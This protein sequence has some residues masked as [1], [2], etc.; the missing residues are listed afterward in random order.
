MGHLSPWCSE[1]PNPT[2]TVRGRPN[3]G[4]N[5][6]L[7][8]LGLEDLSFGLTQTENPGSAA[9]LGAALVHAYLAGRSRT[10]AVSEVR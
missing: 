10:Q 9:A 3:Q 7:F 4:F 1:K 5:S 2:A 6:H 8:G